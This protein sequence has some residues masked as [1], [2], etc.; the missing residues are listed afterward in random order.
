MK[1]IVFLLIPLIAL[2]G[3]SFGEKVRYDNYKVVQFRI[4]NAAQLQRMQNL[5]SDAQGVTFLDSPVATK[6]DLEAVISP[7]EFPVFEEAAKE[8]GMDFKVMEDNFQRLLD[9]ERPARSGRAD[10]FDWTSYN[11]L[12]EIYEW[13]DVLGT[14][15]PDKVTLVTIGQTYEKRPI[16]LAK[17]SSGK[18]VSWFNLFQ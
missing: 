11:T 12:E 8:V 16:R 7:A 18:P 10:R 1:F 9:I 6:K 14:T 5:E 2:A 17:I 15:Y 3:I 13:L 4:E